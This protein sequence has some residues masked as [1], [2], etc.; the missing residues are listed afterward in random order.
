M[1]MRGSAVYGFVALAIV[2]LSIGTAMAMWSETLR[3]NV[4]VN[5]GEVDVKWSSWSCSDTGSDPQAR[6]FSNTEGKDVANC[7]VSVED[8]DDEGDV[9]KLKVTINNAYPGY[10]VVI[11]GVVDN[12]GTVPVKLYSYSIGEY[13]TNALSVDLGI[14]ED[15]QIDPGMNATYTL[16]ITVLQGA[17]EQSSY[18]FE[19][20]LVFAQWNEVT[21]D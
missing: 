21:S 2:M 9:I 20:T 14:P 8:F 19:V 5:T 10:K 11:K 15:T 12:V 7:D 4:E 13:D 6:D 17:E 1:K 16:T 3:M 18:S